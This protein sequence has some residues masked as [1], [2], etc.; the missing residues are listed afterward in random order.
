[1]LDTFALTVHLLLQS[2]IGIL[3]HLFA[4]VLL[5]RYVITGLHSYPYQ[6]VSHFHKQLYA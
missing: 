2:H 1:M 6:D 5:F 3:H 4:M